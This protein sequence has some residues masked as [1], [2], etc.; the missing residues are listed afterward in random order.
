MGILTKIF[1]L[2]TIM[3]MMA[4]CNKESDLPCRV[5]ESCQGLASFY[6]GQEFCPSGFDN[7]EDFVAFFETIAADGCV[8]NEI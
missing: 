1:G 4:A 3:I 7:E 8:C 2:G 5:C 6:N